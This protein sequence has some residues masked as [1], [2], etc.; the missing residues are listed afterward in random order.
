[1]KIALITDTHF[2][3]R[4]GDQALHNHFENFYKNTF[5]PYLQKHNIKTIIHLGD[6]FD[7]RKNI[8]YWSLKWVRNVVLDPIREM[9]ASMTVLAGNH[10]VFYKNTNEVNSPD[11]LLGGYQNIE[12]I[13]E[14]QTK[15]FDKLPIFLIPWINPENYNS[16]MRHI[17]NTQANIAMGHLEISGF[18]AHQGYVCET[19]LDRDIFS[20]KFKKTL[21]GHF[22]HRNNDGKIF[23][24]GNPYQMYW[25]DYGDT[26]GFHI[27]D[28]ENTRMNFI[29]NPYNFFHKIFY[30]D[31]KESYYNFDLEEYKNTNV[32]LIVEHKSDN[33]QFDY[34][35]SA[36]QDIVVDLKIIEELTQDN[37]SIQDVDLEH[38]DTLT[39]LEKCVDEYSEEYDIVAIKKIMK[40]LYKEAI[41]I[42]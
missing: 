5:F 8:D 25:N 38:E 28:T 30:N 37:F 26:R 39:V 13:S 10:D 41:S 20:S 33:T 18:I 6:I 36:L 40:S 27:F 9:G 21:S 32:K 2:G 23:Y 42:G 17:N 34:F 31:S 7:V 29:K 4:K 22:H 12:V 16:V 15:I 3:V 1:M 11:L 24:L 19:G 14:A 35:T